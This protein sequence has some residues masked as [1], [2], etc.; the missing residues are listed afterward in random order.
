VEADD[1]IRGQVAQVLNERELVINRGS[2]DGVKAGMRFAILNR[3]G[4]DIRDPETGESLGS[5]E[6]E[7]AI[8][9]IVRAH[10]RLSVGRTFRTLRRPGGPLAGIAEL[11]SRPSRT[12]VETLRAAGK[13][14]RLE[15][16]PEE[17]LIRVGDPVVETRGEEFQSE[18]DTAKPAGGPPDGY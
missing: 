3:Q 8:V 12:E 13:E 5:V 9:K 4:T 16:N 18:G 14:D 11:V 1:R 10:N 6:I 15:L 17:S 7:K 2:D